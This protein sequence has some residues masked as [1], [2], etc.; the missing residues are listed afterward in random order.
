MSKVSIVTISFNQARFLERAILSVLR[1]EHRDVEYIVVD[2]GSTDG[3]R[4]IIERYRADISHIVLEPD[5]GPADGLNKGFALAT[6]A[7]W[8]FLNADD[9]LLPYALSRAV[10]FLA[11]HSDIDVVSAHASI[12]DEDDHEIRKAFSDRLSLTRYAYGACVLLQPSTFFRPEVFKRA[13]GFNRDNRCTWDGE[14]FV[15]M[16]IVG[17]RFAVVDD[18]WSGFRLQADSITASASAKIEAALA[19]YRE[20]IFLHIMGRPRRA[21]D[22]TIAAFMRVAKHALNPRNALQRILHGRIYGRYSRPAA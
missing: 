1:Q 21:Y 4:E 19:R 9:V 10:S 6:G 22:P 3:S 18:V 12:I 13:G 2:P 5:S 7:V 20:R 16:K 8:G 17:A 11:A 15:A 14:L